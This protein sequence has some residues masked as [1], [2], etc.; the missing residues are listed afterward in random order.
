M[1]D[2]TYILEAD[3][4]GEE[5][6]ELQRLANRLSRHHPKLTP[7]ISGMLDKFD[8]GIAG[9]EPHAAER[10]A[11]AFARAFRALWLDA[12]G[13][14]A[15]SVYRSPTASETQR[16]ARH[17][18]AF[19]YERDL[20]PET[21][22]R[23]C[24][25]FFSAPPPGWRQEHILFSSG[26]AAMTTALLVLGR[27]IAS[28]GPTLRLAHRGTY[29]ET[30]ALIRSLPFIAEA[31]FAQTA[32][33]VIDE[34]VCCDGQFHQIDTGKQLSASPCAVI[35]DTTLMGRKDGVREY[36]AALGA[37]GKQIVMRVASCLKLLQGGFEL[38]IVGVLSVHTSHASVGGLGDKLRRMR[39][40]TGS[41]LHL[42][43]AI[44]LEAPWVFD[45][46]HADAYASAIFDHNARLAYAVQQ[47]NTRFEPVTHPAFGGGGAPFCS[48]RLQKGNLE[49][50]DALDQEIAAEA[51]RRRLNL[52]RGG[53]F[54]FRAHCYEIVKP[55]TGEAPFLRIALGRRGGWSCEG[56]IVMMA[57]L[58]AK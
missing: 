13:S 29:F 53:S 55:E 2:T 19:G 50:Y 34:P 5:V 47:S 18:D 38:A 33:L 51:L 32:D 3:A 7:Q 52:V 4:L 26:Q 14:E 6:R 1:A 37:G 30:R 11:E 39:T 28:D 12:A 16:I 17:H 36:L 58:A 9:A 20:Q 24:R 56:V 23:R 49:A 46:N 22:E 57:Q 54:G 31:T 35:F 25:D 21:L 44:A 40:L 15:S 8:A 48:F 42:V 41:G 45:P 27:H 10:A 43:D